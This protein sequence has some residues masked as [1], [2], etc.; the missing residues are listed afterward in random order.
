MN[1]M[2]TKVVSHSGVQFQVHDAFCVEAA[3]CF[4]PCYSSQRHELGTLKHHQ[5]Q[6]KIEVVVKVGKSERKKIDRERRKHLPWW[7][8]EE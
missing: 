7:V 2:I 8:L 1:V 6:R 5:F 4:L 3:Q